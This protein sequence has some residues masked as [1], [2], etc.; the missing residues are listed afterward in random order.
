V[1]RRVEEITIKKKKGIGRGPRG[2]ILERSISIGMKAYS[3]KEGTNHRNV[4]EEKSSL[5]HL[6]T[7]FYLC[8]LPALATELKADS[9]V[10]YDL[11]LTK[12]GKSEYG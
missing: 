3:K 2:S 1:V 11:V 4:A 10:A 6:E 8:P 9:L 7:L 5:N 12:Q